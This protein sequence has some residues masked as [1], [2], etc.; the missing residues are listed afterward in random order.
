MGDPKPIKA[1]AAFPRLA[2][3]DPGAQRFL[4]V[5]QAVGQKAAAICGKAELGAEAER[6]AWEET[7]GEAP[8]QTTEDWKRWACRVGLDANWIVGGE[9]TPGEVLPLVEGYLQRQ[10]DQGAA[11][12]AAADRPALTPEERA[13]VFVREHLKRTGNLPPKTLIAEKL[14]VDRRTLHN[15]KAFKVA[16]VQMKSQLGMAPARGTK[17]RDGNLD[18]WRE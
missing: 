5:L 7:F 18:A 14:G 1:G 9:W 16:Y 4:A 15:W 6:R 8:P 3:N 11:S 13:I 10:K 2:E 12:K 17:D